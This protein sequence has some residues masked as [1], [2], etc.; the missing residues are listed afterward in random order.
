MSSPPAAAMTAV[1]L[2]LLVRMVTPV[3]PQQGS[4]H[5]QYGTYIGRLTA[6]VEGISG[7]VRH[8]SICVIMMS[9]IPPSQVYVVDNKHL[10]I[11]NFRY[12]KTGP[13][14]W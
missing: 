2:L 6:Y 8:R 5:P 4:Y 14:W 10:F 12:E 1:S 7:R 9:Y 11:R 3:L 13:G